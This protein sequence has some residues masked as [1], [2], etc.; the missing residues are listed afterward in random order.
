MLYAKFVKAKSG[1]KSRRNKKVT[2]SFYRCYRLNRKKMVL[3]QCYSSNTITVLIAAYLLLPS[4]TVLVLRPL[5][6]QK[7][8]TYGWEKQKQV[9]DWRGSFHFSCVSERTPGRTKTFQFTT[10]GPR[11]SFS[12]RLA[13]VVSYPMTSTS[14]FR[15]HLLRHP[16]VT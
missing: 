15:L 12:R 13:Q 16:P 6:L 3:E 10:A 11:S 4:R 2:G 7:C 5:Q 14:S 9:T 8:C 1:T